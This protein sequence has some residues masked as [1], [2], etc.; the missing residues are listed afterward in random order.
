MECQIVFIDQ[1][2]QFPLVDLSSDDWAQINFDDLR[3]ISRTVGE[4][5]DLV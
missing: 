3:E 5:D 4:K 2:A 1:S